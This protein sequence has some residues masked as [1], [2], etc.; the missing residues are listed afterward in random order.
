MRILLIFLLLFLTGCTGANIRSEV[1]Q[2]LALDTPSPPEAK[3]KESQFFDAALVR[4]LPGFSNGYAVVN[5]IKIHYVEGGKGEPLVLLA[6]WAET[7]WEYHKMMPALAK[8]FH[9]IAVD[10]RGMGGSDKPVSGYDKK[11]MASD[12]HALVNKL[13]YKKVNITGHDIGSMVAFSFASNYPEATNRLAMLDVPHPFDAFKE[14]PLMPPTGA[15]DYADPNHPR[16]RWWFAFHAVPELPEK[17]IEGK[18]GVYINW[19]MDYLAYDK[20][21][22]SEFDRQVNT[23]AYSAPNAIRAG[24]NWFRT[25]PQDINDLANY[26]N[27]EIPV[28]GIGSFTYDLLNLFLPAHA[29]NLRIVKLEKTGH[30]IPEEAPEETNKL[31]IEFFK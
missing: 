9:V 4:S 16:H 8:K 27:L 30:W 18:V 19:M 2:G 29:L 23:A 15:Y 1:V 13:G 14:I 28:L 24:V 21:S 26:K 11:T 25:F 20:K 12:I 17:L 6:G 22:I 31:L 7:W 3:A 10:L 5:G